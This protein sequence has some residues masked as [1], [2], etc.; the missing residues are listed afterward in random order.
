M[1]GQRSSF[2]CF[3]DQQPVPIETSVTEAI[4]GRRA[5]RRQMTKKVHFS[6]TGTCDLA[7]QFLSESVNYAVPEPTPEDDVIK[8][9]W[10]DTFAN[11][12]ISIIL[13]VM[14]TRI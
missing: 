12:R 6:E 1:Q 9:H 4:D 5:Y 11:E 10:L 2:L 7:R 13:Q 14:I 8:H 3:V